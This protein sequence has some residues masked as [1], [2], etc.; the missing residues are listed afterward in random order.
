MKKNS[1]I[2]IAMVLVAL[3]PFAYLALVW[4]TIP[5]MVPLHFNSNLE[6]DR[7]GDKSELLGVV[8]IVASVSIIVFFLLKN[9]HR[10]DPK[11]KNEPQSD[12]FNKLAI[13]LMIFMTALN[14]LILI[15]SIKGVRLMENLLFPLLGLL[16]AFIGNYMNNI[17]PNYFA[18][19]RLPWTLS[20]DE[21]WKKTHH[22]ASKLWFWGGLFLTLISLLL[23][24]KIV[25][26]F[27][28]AVVFILTLIPCIY[29]YQL[30]KRKT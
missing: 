16:F 28:M 3:I 2:N 1:L 18:G 20:S 22:L 9:I 6:A 27:F 15:S 7:M 25:I 21:N 11:R 24:L 23:P 12:T 8:S 29:S 17:K 5:T 14:L 13:G 10:F 30:F 26:P 4:N 19:I